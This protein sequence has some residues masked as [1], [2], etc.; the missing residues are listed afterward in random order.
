MIWNILFWISLIS[1]VVF[2]LYLLWN[3]FVYIFYT[4]DYEPYYG[5]TIPLYIIS[6]IGAVIIIIFYL[7]SK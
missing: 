2:T 5:G 6:L 1:T 4:Q 7:L 3:T